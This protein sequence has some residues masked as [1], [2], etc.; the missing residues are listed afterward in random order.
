MF[1]FVFIACSLAGLSTAGLSTEVPP[2]GPND[3]I[4]EARKYF[5]E[6]PDAPAISPKGYDVTIVE[7]LDY[8]CPA[9]RT[10]REPLRKLLEKDKK[11]RLIFR[12]LP[13]FGP[14]SEK[15]ARLALASKY[16]GKYFDFHD[17]LLAASRPLDDD[18]IKAAALKAGV[19]WDLLQK[20]MFANK[21]DI[22]DLLERNE[23]QADMLGLDGTPGFIIG[24]TQSFGGLTLEQLEESVRDARK[25]AA[26]GGSK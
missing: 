6:D 13:I 23:L 11:I 14:A 24:S 2:P 12:D 7:Y 3:P 21:K 26:K 5:T 16:Q 4:E 9:C 22:E 8:Q 20:D 18:K 10:T 25:E 17:A 1:R 15:A 19:D